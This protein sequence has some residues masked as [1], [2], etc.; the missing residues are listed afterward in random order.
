VS[1]PDGSYAACGIPDARLL[2]V[3]AQIGAKKSAKVS[4][5]VGEGDR[6]ASV[7]VAIPGT[8]AE[9]FGKSVT[10]RVR[11]AFGLP[12]PHALV[13]VDG[14]RGRVAD[15]SGRVVF[16]VAGDT[17]KLDVRRI[18]FTPFNGRV[19][20]GANGEL[21]VELKALAQALAA[22]TVVAKGAGTSLD[23]TGF[24]DRATR[25]QRGA[26]IGEFITPEELELRNLTRVTDILQGRQYSS[27]KVVKRDGHNLSVVLGRAGCVM[28]VVI[29]GQAVKGSAQDLQ[30][31][32]IPTS[33]DGRG[34]AVSSLGA[35]AD[36]DE[37]I[38]GRSVMGIEIY[39]SVAGAPV[40]LIPT[41]SRGGCGLVVIWTG[42]RR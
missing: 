19:G 22:V 10:V 18:G 31:G 11:D 40:E 33:I 29:D 28:N 21:R 23:K 4:V 30:V 37:L 27:I 34:S 1:G 32:T 26:T 12:I 42:G 3:S 39:P 8:R 35:G 25:V 24:Y 5:R 7:D 14:G 20:R 9:L 13:S 15:D 16:D 41:A 36:L 17:L 38:D 2:A 6:R